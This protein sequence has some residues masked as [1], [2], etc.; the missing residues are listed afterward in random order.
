MPSII[1][2][3]RSHYGCEYDKLEKD[4]LASAYWYDRAKIGLEKKKAD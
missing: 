1:Y 2:N 4:L 3:V